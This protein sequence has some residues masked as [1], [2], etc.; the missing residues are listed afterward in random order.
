[1]SALNRKHQ[2]SYTIKRGSATENI[3]F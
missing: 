3:P 2:T 1:M